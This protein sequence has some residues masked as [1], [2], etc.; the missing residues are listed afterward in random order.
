M[1]KAGGELAGKD[2]SIDF[3]ILDISGYELP[4]APSKTWREVIKKVWE[5]DFLTCPR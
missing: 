4:H 3:T 5:I 2:Y 1:L